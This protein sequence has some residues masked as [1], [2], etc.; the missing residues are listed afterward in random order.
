MMQWLPFLPWYPV[1]G[2]LL[3]LFAI[4]L[5]IWVVYNVEKTPQLPWA[6]LIIAII[7]IG[8]AFGLG[9]HLILYHLAM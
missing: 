8:L 7:I 4:L 6:K 9:L 1:Y 2:G 5:S 3:L